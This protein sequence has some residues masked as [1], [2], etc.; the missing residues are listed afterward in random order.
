MICE[1]CRKPV[2]HIRLCETSH[3]MRFEVCDDCLVARPGAFTIIG[4]CHDDDPGSFTAEQ[5]EAYTQ[6]SWDP[7]GLLEIDDL[8]DPDPAFDD[9]EFEDDPVPP[10]EEGDL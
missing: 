7:E 10:E 8:E 4:R 6:P 3:G 5:V 1:L 2:P 9:D